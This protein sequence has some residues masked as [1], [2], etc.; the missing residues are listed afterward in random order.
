VS[1]GHRKTRAG[2]AK[3]RPTRYRDGATSPALTLALRAHRKGLMAEAIHGY[4]AVIE[5]D[6]DCLDAWMNLA[7]LLALRGVASGASRAFA[8]ALLLAP[9]DARAHRDAGIGL[10][11]VGDLATARGAFERSVALDPSLLG[12]R[13]GLARLCGDLGDEDAWRHHA[14]LAIEA[15]PQ[16]AS[17]HLELHRALFDD[18]SLGPCIAA[19][20]R[21]VALDP[22]YALARYFLAG[23]LLHEGRRGEAEEALGPAG[24]VA[25][26]LRDAL[27]YAT[28][29]PHRARC[30]ST[31]RRTLSFALAQSGLP[32]AVLELGVRHGVSTRVLAEQA[33]G[34]VHGFDSFVGLP[35]AWQ[36]RAPGAFSTAGELPAVPPSVRLHVGLFAETLPAFARTL[37]EPVR[38]L[39]V[40]SDLY[41]SALTGLVCLAPRIQTGTI[42]V[43]DEYLGNASWRQDEHRALAEASARFGWAIEE[44]SLGWITGQGVVRVGEIRDRG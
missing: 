19:A 37:A 4:K 3:K 2:G 8:Q 35:E 13:L 1:Q 34:V 36:E 18:G 31:K 25:P 9:D 7:S 23:A 17:T 44:L 24:L 39:H 40:D 15:A 5:Q 32:G 10:V 12:A 14:H 22:G 29:H 27:E 26:G 16:D 33:G 38:L 41:E 6:R 28:C 43:F 30:F 20:R 11:A 21:A 42:I